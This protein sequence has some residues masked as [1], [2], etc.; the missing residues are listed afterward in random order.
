MHIRHKLRLCFAAALLVI[1]AVGCGPAAAK[2]TMAGFW[3]DADNNVTTIED[4]GTAFAATSVFNLSQ[5]D[6]QNTLVSSSY[7]Y[8]A[9]TWR[10]CPSAKPCLTLQTRT[11]NGDTLD[12]HWQND[13]GETGQ[14]TLKR[15]DKGTH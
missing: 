12:V 15:V 7:G 4:Q 14:M 3:A 2:A 11:L 6:S 8:R 10:Y 1:L 13:N 5:S 9:L